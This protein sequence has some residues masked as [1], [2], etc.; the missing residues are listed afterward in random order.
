VEALVA[1]ELTE[2]EECNVER[3][4]RRK[5]R[6]ERVRSDDH[7]REDNRE[8]YLLK[9]VGAVVVSEYRTRMA[10]DTFKKHAKEVRGLPLRAVFIYVA[11]MAYSL[12]II[13]EREKRS[14]T[15]TTSLTLF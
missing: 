15:R 11:D 2:E 5:D 4:R 1:E 10:V 12:H 13:A 9:L 3:E 6:K 7:G 14:S 8:K